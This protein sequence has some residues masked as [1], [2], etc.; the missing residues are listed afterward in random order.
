MKYN[1]TLAVDGRIT[2]EVE[3]TSFKNA[4]DKAIDAF[5]DT[6]IGDIECVG[7]T[8]VNAESKDGVFVDF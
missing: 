1:V 3:A 5:I 6:N 2:L 4:K 8:A 7:L